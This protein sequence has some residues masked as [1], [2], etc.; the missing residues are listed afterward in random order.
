MLD[1][2]L[3]DLVMAVKRRALAG[4]EPQP[5]YSISCTYNIS[6]ELRGAW[7][8]G[9]PGVSVLQVGPSYEASVAR[10][11]LVPCTPWAW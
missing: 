5:F 4:M 10:Q 3:C 2:R 8:V 7:H 1:H 11:G 6:T 9:W